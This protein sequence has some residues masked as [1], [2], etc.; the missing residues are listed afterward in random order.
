MNENQLNENQLNYLRREYKK[1][2]AYQAH[3]YQENRELVLARR[4]E[5][6][7]KN[8]KKLSEKIRCECG[9]TYQIPSKNRHLL[10]AKHNYYINIIKNNHIIDNNKNNNTKS[11]SNIIINKNKIIDFEIN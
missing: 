7:D 4:K 2:S 6:R 5:Y 11:D 10:T 9:G 1:Y 3:Y 8:E